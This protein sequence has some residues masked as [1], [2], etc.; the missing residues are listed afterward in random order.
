[1]RTETLLERIELTAAR[2][3]EDTKLCDL[4]VFLLDTNIFS[5]YW[6]LA[7]ALSY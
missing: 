4:R 1:M 5:I 6:K 2:L 7:L 3:V